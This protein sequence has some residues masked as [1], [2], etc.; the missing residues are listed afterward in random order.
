MPKKAAVGVFDPSRKSGRSTIWLVR[1]GKKGK[2][3]QRMDNSGDK[4]SRTWQG[5]RGNWYRSAQLGTKRPT[6]WGRRER[7]KRH[8]Q[9]KTRVCEHFVAPSLV[10]SFLVVSKELCTCSLSSQSLG[11]PPLSETGLMMILWLPGRL[12]AGLLQQRRIGEWTVIDV[13]ICGLAPVG[14]RGLWSAETLENLVPCTLPSAE[15][16]TSATPQFA[17]PAAMYIRSSTQGM[18]TAL[19]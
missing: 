11:S 13:P 9:G 18:Y 15:R 10:V 4:L 19:L 7:E 16:S 3:E 6:D 17:H 1:R 8:I 2:D 12:A 14:F 5:H